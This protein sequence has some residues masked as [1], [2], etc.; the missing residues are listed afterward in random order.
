MLLRRRD[1]RSA[2]WRSSSGPHAPF[3]AQQQVARDR[4]HDERDDEQDEAERDQRR[5]IEIAHRFGELI[6]DGGRNG[7]ARMQEQADTLCALPI[8]KVTAMVSPSARPSPS[9]TPPMTP[10]RV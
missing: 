4:Q 7:R 3:D 1:G 5:G 2:G 9:M 8:T 6:G 10:T